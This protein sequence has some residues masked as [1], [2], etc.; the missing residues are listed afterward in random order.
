MILATPEKD[1]LKGAWKGEKKDYILPESA[2]E[3]TQSR[4]TLCNP[5]DCSLPHSSIHG[6]LQARVLEWGAI[7]FS[8]GY[9]RPR[10]R[11]QVSHIVGRRFYHLRADL[12]EAKSY[13]DVDENLLTRERNPHQRQSVGRWEAGTHPPAGHQPSPASPSNSSFCSRSTDKLGL[14]HFPISPVF[15]TTSLGRAIPCALDARFDFSKCKSSCGKESVFL[16]LSAES[17]LP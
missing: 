14:S 12:S 1:I 2:S 3:A 4:L 6:I 8:R 7:S 10:D 16:L 5:M 9:S 17:H 13:Q 15:L 11:T